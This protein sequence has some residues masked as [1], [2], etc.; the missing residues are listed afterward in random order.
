[1]PLI[2]LV[3]LKRR[4]ITRYKPTLLD[5][6]MYEFINYLIHNVSNAS[7]NSA[8]PVHPTPQPTPATHPTRSRRYFTCGG[9]EPMVSGV[10]YNTGGES[11]PMHSGVG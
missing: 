8:E 4:L 1:M 5:K 10:P 2:R 3:Y 7:E 11:P 9:D 6:V